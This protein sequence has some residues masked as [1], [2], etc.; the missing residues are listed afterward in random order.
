MF[1]A[2]LNDKRAEVKYRNDNGARAAVF[3]GHK[4]KNLTWSQ[5]LRMA[6]NLVNSGRSVVFLPELVATSSADALVMFKGRPVIAD[7]KYLVT[8]K[9]N[10]IALDLEQGFSQAGTLVVQLT[11]ADLGQFRDGVDQLRRKIK[12]TKDGSI[13]FGNI[14]LMNEYGE[15]REITAKMLRQNIYTNKIKGF[16]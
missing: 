8:R 6:E 10:T 16:L 15:I 11:K 5:T 1:D 3:E 2:I 12:T 9:A 4:T 7:F 14:I 13:R